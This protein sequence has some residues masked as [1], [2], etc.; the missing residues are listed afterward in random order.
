MNFPGSCPLDKAKCHWQL[1]RFVDVPI[2]IMEF[3]GV[4]EFHM[5]VAVFPNFCTGIFP[6]PCLVHAHLSHEAKL[7]DCRHYMDGSLSILL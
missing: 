3:L 4:L 5:P 6:V 2:D 1:M 7:C